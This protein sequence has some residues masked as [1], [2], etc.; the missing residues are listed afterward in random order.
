MSIMLFLTYTTY[1]TGTTTLSQDHYRL[2]I[3]FF[4]KLIGNRV[5]RPTEIVAGPRSP[6]LQTERLTF[7]NNIPRRSDSFSTKSI[8]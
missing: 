1:Y 2:I 6:M 8:E 7:I 5:S 4:L 3:D